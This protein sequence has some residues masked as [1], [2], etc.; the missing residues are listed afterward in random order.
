MSRSIT[1]EQFNT[2]T[3]DTKSMM[4]NLWKGFKKSRELSPNN[5]I[6]DSINI[7]H[8]RF[9]LDNDTKNTSYQKDVNRGFLNVPKKKHDVGYYS[10]NHSMSNYGGVNYYS[11]NL[12]NSIDDSKSRVFN[13]SALKLSDNKKEVQKSILMCKNDQINI[14]TPSKYNR[15]MSPKES[16]NY[17][18]QSNQNFEQTKESGQPNNQKKS[19]DYEKAKKIVMD[20]QE[21]N[22]VLKKKY[23]SSKYEIKAIKKELGQYKKIAKEF[24]KMDSDTVNLNIKVKLLEND[25]KRL[26][27]LLKKTETHKQVA[28]TLDAKENQTYVKRK[29]CNKE[30]QLNTEN[31]RLTRKRSLTRGSVNSISKTKHKNLNSNG[32]NYNN[33]FKRSCCGE[34]ETCCESVTA[35]SYNHPKA[36][37]K[38]VSWQELAN[39]IPGEARNLA[40]IFK[41]KY[42]PKVSDASI[43]EFI[44][45]INEIFL[46]NE[47][48]NLKHL[49][50]DFKSDIN[51]LKMKNLHITGDK[52]SKEHFK[53]KESS[54]KKRGFMDG[55]LW[56]IDK[57]SKDILKM[58]K[59]VDIQASSNLLFGAKD[60][61]TMKL[62]DDFNSNLT[63]VFNKLNKYQKYIAC[64]KKVGNTKKTKKKSTEKITICDTEDSA[65]DSVS[66]LSDSFSNLSVDISF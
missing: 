19:V 27:T 42:L 6:K 29:G 56:I 34:N 4:K 21:E 51:Q 3:E 26:T 49:K 48:K 28:E 18:T 53:S 9:Q 47:E 41:N 57:L 24:N 50:A 14:N 23:A 64:Q 16:K 66:E 55:S 45:K 43:I 58:Q 36:I 10:S 35:E 62:A 11:C 59:I 63:K 17:Y 8:S 38:T 37:N 46:L 39:W 15:D 30:N 31:S 33:N 12:N 52:Y 40:L 2:Q 65:L 54:V 20:L 22:T 13:N 1:G 32:L 5:I 60:T 61:E 25:I 44:R 7:T